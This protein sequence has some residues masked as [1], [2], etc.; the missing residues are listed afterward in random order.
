M[1]PRTSV[2]NP[3]QGAPRIRGSAHDPHRRPALIWLGGSVLAAHLG[4]LVSPWFGGSPTWIWFALIALVTLFM[5]GMGIRHLVASVRDDRSRLGASIGLCVLPAVAILI[6]PFAGLLAMMFGQLHLAAPFAAIAVGIVLL[7]RRPSSRASRPWL[8]AAAGLIALA[9][10]LS[11]GVADSLVL[12]PT[13]LVPELTLPEINAE[14]AAAD[15]HHG[16]WMPVFWAASWFV[17]GSVLAAGLLR[18]RVSARV[19]AGLLLATAAVAT[20]GLWVTQF[21]IGMGIADTFFTSGGV[22]GA[23]PV[24][25][26]AAALTAAGAAGLLTRR[27]SAA[28]PV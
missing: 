5:L 26:A 28:H 18:N 12:L 19:S 16:R 7:V 25:M 10:L 1:S 11:L 21:A 17:G 20:S 23:F 27:S 8:G 3:L 22:S 13:G 15:E 2:P 24:I 4:G 9:A 6:A 14:L